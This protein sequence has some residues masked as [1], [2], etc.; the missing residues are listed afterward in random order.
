MHGVS[1]FCIT[2]RAVDPHWRCVINAAARSAGD[3]A[4]CHL[5]TPQTYFQRT[6][7]PGLQHEV[8]EWQAQRSTER[9]LRHRRI[10]ILG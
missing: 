3:P 4:W 9:F 1:D 6:Q 2:V 10:N 7:P 8:L 5:R